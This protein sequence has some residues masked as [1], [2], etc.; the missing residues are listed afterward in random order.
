MSSPDSRERPY[1]LKRGEGR[2]YNCGVDFIVKA[3]EMRPGSGAAILEYSTRKGEE[4][5]DHTHP[6]E[7]EVFYVLEGAVS[8][9]CDGK[10]FDVEEGGFVFLP[11]G[12]EH[13][14]TIRSDGTVRLLVVTFPVREGAGG[15]GGFVGEMERAG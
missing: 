3:G 7:D 15:W 5:Q 6:T 1:A 9:H 10:T 8:F 14:Y 13:G 11:R 12:I 2:I 4:P